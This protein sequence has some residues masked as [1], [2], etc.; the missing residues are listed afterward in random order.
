MTDNNTKNPNEKQPGEKP[1]GTYHF[2]PGN[3][4]GKSQSVP[5]D[6]PEPGN[7]RDAVQNPDKRPRE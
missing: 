6:R 2:N 3:Q 4:S 1:D 7:N 5:K